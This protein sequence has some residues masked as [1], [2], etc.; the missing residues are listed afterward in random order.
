MTRILD[1]Q[2]AQFTLN[3]TGNHESASTWRIPAKMTPEIPRRFSTAPT[4]R[5]FGK[6]PWT[7]GE[8]Q[9][10]REYDY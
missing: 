8:G 4:H 6:R 2:S 7:I 3:G 1:A 5:R 10:T 9:M